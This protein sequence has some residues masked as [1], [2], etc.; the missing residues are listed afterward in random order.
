MEQAF[1]PA[2]EKAADQLN[3][4]LWGKISLTIFCDGA[5][6]HGLKQC[7]LFKD[8]KDPYR[9]FMTQAKSYSNAEKIA[10]RWARCYELQEKHNM[11]DGTDVFVN[12]PITKKP[13]PTKFYTHKEPDFDHNDECR[14]WH[15]MVMS[16]DKI[17]DPKKKCAKG[18]ELTYPGYT[19][20]LKKISL[21]TFLDSN[22]PDVLVYMDESKLT[23]LDA[24]RK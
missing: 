22:P 17:T 8:A 7:A 2:I 1:S 3:L 19:E 11:P 13:E 12:E 6:E 23:L 21:T 20:W 4:N 16:W 10:L 5:I 18:Y 24:M 15:D 14:K 9:Y